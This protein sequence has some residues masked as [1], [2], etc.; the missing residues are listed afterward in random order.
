MKKLIFK[1]VISSYC[2]LLV[3]CQKETD[4]SI[5]GG[6][7]FLGHT[8]QSETEVDERL[9][10]LGLDRYEHI[11]LGG[12]ICG[13]SDRKRSTVEYVNNLFN[14]NKAGNHWALGNHDIHDNNY[15]WIEEV[16][17]KPEFYTEY[18]DGL[19]VMVIN[20]NLYEPECDRLAAQYEMFKNVCDTISESSHLVV[21]SHHVVWNHVR[22]IPNLW[23]RANANKPF[24]EARCEPNSRFEQVMY[25]ELIEVQNRGVQVL[26]LAGDYGQKEKY[27][28]QKAN[29]G[30]WFFGS[31]I[32]HSN[33]YM[34]DS[35][36][37]SAKDLILFFQH[38]KVEKT[39]DWQFLDLDSL[40]Q[41]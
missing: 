5:K 33:R 27:F 19:T 29:S 28:Q 22:E 36:K 2:L 39:L 13:A 1:I 8:Y 35:L 32:D 37:D 17:G 38:D 15:H 20:T 21:L 3:A 26:I 10:K 25:N 31:G 11:W 6:I 18:N 7:L 41:K 24:W 4:H 14:L 34:P 9:V 12:D 30:I 40:V 16:T 23:E